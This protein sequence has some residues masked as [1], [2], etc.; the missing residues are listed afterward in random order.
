M[1]KKKVTAIVKLQCPAGKA[2]VCVGRLVPTPPY[3]GSDVRLQ[4]ECR[5]I[6][7]KARPAPI[8]PWH[9]DGETRSAGRADRPRGKE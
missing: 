9:R 5:R 7:S 1:A 3:V 2:H 6:L 8:V 4:G